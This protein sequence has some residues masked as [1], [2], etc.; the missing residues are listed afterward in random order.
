MFLPERSRTAA[1][2]ALKDLV[3]EHQ[4]TVR[5]GQGKLNRK[6]RGEA[7]DLRLSIANVALIRIARD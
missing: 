1:K 6:A 7:I 3:E 5:G 2:F 4:W